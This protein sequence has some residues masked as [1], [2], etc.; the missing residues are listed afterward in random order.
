[1]P[2]PMSPPT[3]LQDTFPAPPAPAGPGSTP[4]REGVRPPWRAVG[5]ILV[6]AL[7]VPVF[8]L[9]LEERPVSNILEE[10]VAITAREMW[11]N[12]EWVLPTMNGEPR[13]QKPPLAYWLVHAHAA[14]QGAFDDGVLRHPFGLLA[15]GTAL[16]AWATGRRVFGDAAGIL[17]AASLVTMALFVKEGRMATADPAMLFSAAG[18][19]YFYVRA[20]V[21][22]EPFL[23]PAPGAAAPTPRRVELDRLGFY[24]FLGLGALAKGPPI[25]LV[26]VVPPF[27]E[28]I[29]TRSRDPLRP[30][31]SWGGLAVFLILSLTWPA[32]V[33]HRLS[34]S[35]PAGAALHQW[36][37]ES[38]GKVLP[39][40]GVEGGYKFQRHPGPWYFYFPRV[41]S[42]YGFWSPAVIAGV[43]L[44]WRRRGAARV[45]WT[46][47]LVVFGAFSLV[48]E[49]KSAYV[50]PTVFPAALVVGDLLA[51]TH[52]SARRVL[53]PVGMFLATLGA[54]CLLACVAGAAAPSR[55]T[56]LATSL[57]GG[58][59]G[60]V[61]AAFTAKPLHL[62][63]AGL[64]VF[65]GTMGLL[66][67]ARSES[68]LRAY[69]PL[70][71]ALSLSTWF[72]NEL[73]SD[74]PIDEGDPRVG[75]RA[76][77]ERVGQEI[78]LWCVGTRSA[79]AVGSMPAGLIYYLDRR[80][81]LVEE[82]NLALLETLPEHAGI[83]V[84]EARLLKLSPPRSSGTGTPRA[85]GVTDGRPV[86]GPFESFVPRGP[87][88]P[89]IAEARDRVWVLI[90]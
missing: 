85:E 34:Q 77:A 13:L 83:L 6:A 56:E 74:L 88:N 64:T 18:A 81:G 44:G 22:A 26:C 59:A 80:V 17:A 10:R 47:L 2:P 84:S 19:W 11:R 70:A 46:L 28:A 53:R 63:L 8:F 82:R 55:A 23:S 15:V 54:L 9:P 57:L 87:I 21:R 60:L 38:M 36:W 71:A 68:P 16:F 30:L 35:Q 45:P 42:V 49:K 67:G 32:L 52:D 5:P 89:G 20:R 39:S 50:L 51:S 90:R 25:L 40:S 69:L 72:Y 41:F 62:L 86:P 78:P 37:L 14:L 1:M 24:L 3:S 58:E 79:G 73:K 31:A 75:A 4:R 66:L 12:E 29:V 33:I 43:L 76:I 48:S 7:A 27:V 65:L 61:V